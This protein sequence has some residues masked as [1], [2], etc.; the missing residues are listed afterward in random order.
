M[1]LAPDTIK[2]AGP[3]GKGEGCGAGPIVEEGLD[4]NGSAFEG[5]DISV[6]EGV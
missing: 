1:V 5:T 4:F 2:I 3:C 6:D